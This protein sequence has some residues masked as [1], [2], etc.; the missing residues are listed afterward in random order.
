MKFKLVESIDDRLV[1][2][3]LEEDTK[4]AL[5]KFQTMV[6]KALGDDFKYVVNRPNRC[7]DIFKDDKLI[8]QAF[9]KYQDKLDAKFYTLVKL[10]SLDDALP[11]DTLYA[12][13]K[14]EGAKAQICGIDYIKNVHQVALTPQDFLNKII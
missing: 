5:E 9:P 14:K 4:K 1:E 2:E 8:G 10:D 11:T 12:K 7:V 6:K 13:R 3:V